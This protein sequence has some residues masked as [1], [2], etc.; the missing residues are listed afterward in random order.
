ML[1][2]SHHDETKKY[3]KQRVR[4]ALNKAKHILKGRELKREADKRQED[5]A[6]RQSPGSGQ[7]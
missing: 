1:R 3:E 5:R 6:I 4:T 7:Y 2:S